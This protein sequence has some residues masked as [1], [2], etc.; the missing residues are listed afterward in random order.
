MA[1]GGDRPQGAVFLD[2][3]QAGGL[4]TVFAV[5]TGEAPMSDPTNVIMQAI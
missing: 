2:L 3:D 4:T 1:T 5:I